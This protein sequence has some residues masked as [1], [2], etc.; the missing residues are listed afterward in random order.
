MCGK[1]DLFSRKMVGL[2]VPIMV[3]A[4]HNVKS[5]RLMDGSRNGLSVPQIGLRVGRFQEE[6]TAGKDMVF[7]LSANVS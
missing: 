6:P 5:M 7:C 2:K 1:K 3:P 4:D